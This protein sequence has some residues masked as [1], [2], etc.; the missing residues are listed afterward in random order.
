M[1][2]YLRTP[3]EKALELNNKIKRVGGK[4]AFLQ[5]MAKRHPQCKAEELIAKVTY[6]CKHGDE[7]YQIFNNCKRGLGNAQLWQL[8]KYIDEMIEEVSG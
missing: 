1:S 8:I 3:G 5:W 4:Q 2:R 7:A 6:Y